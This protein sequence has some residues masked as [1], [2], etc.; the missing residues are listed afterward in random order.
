MIHLVDNVEACVALYERLEP[1]EGVA[2][3]G[4]EQFT[5]HVIKEWFSL[6]S[7]YNAQHSEK[8]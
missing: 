5:Y 4:A 1:Y 2:I 7:L 8:R 6:L 3:S